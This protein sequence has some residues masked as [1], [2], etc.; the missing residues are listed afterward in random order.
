MSVCFYLPDVGQCAMLWATP[1]HI[2]G[3]ILF[4]SCKVW[5]VSSLSFCCL[6]STRVRI[7]VAGA[8]PIWRPDSEATA[9]AHPPCGLKFNFFRRKHHVRLSCVP[10]VC[11]VLCLCGGGPAFFFFFFHLPSIPLNSVLLRSAGVSPTLLP[12]CLL[13]F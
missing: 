10:R 2:V 6:I 5:Y 8:R 7:C 3:S 4:V 9:C 13:L 12:G 1:H 11:R